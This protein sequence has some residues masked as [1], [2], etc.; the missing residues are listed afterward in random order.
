MSRQPLGCDGVGM[1]QSACVCV[2]YNGLLSDRLVWLLAVRSLSA[3]QLLP[4]HKGA[5]RLEATMQLLWLAMALSVHS[6]AE[7]HTLQ[8]ISVKHQSHWDTKNVEIP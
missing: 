5:P 6:V 3:V 2:L 1:A 4:I 8:L 7:L